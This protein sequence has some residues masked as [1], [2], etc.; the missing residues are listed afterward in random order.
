M[1]ST[2]PTPRPYTQTSRAQA[3]EA[4]AQRIIE[5]FIARLMTEW[6]DEIT[7]DAVAADAGVTVQTIIRRFGGKEALLAAAVPVFG[8]Q[9]RARRAVPA[10]APLPAIITALL[11]DYEVSG[12]A[13]IRLL[14][15]ELRFPVL[16]DYLNVG[17][18]GHR[19]WVADAF[20]PAL[21]KLP[22]ASRERTLDA[23]IIATDVFTWKLLRRDMHRSRDL[24]AATLQQL[25]AGALAGTA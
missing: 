2:P 12:D 18:T 8:D 23:L 19:Q 20:A 9:V 5:A 1:K 6:F 25:I 17:R 4:T 22:P 15:I 16:N 21:A 24:T 14:A 7:L 13:V 3:A 11:D 10:G